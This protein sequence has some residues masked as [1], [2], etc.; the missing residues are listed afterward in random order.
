MA[1]PAAAAATTAPAPARRRGAFTLVELLVVITV[2][3]ILMGMVTSGVVVAMR[4][5]EETRIR[6]LVTFLRPPC[7]RFRDDH[8]SYPWTSPEKVTA[9]TVID[10]AAVY[11]ELRGLPGATM[12]PSID[13][14]KALD[15]RFVKTVAGKPRLQDGWGADI[16]FRVDPQNLKPVIW[17]RGWDGVDDTNF[18]DPPAKYTRYTPPGPPPAFSNPAKFP[19][20]Y[21]YLGDGRSRADDLSSL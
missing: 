8:G 21:Y 1:E 6:T 12:N 18:E 2:I 7:E 5:A 10:P 13:Y 20:A 15:P 11:A 17:S 14:L 19:R 9:T 16:V 4:K 3:C